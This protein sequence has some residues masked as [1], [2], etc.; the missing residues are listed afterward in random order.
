MGG[1]GACIARNTW[2]WRS[3]RQPPAPG[4][5]KYGLQLAV[6]RTRGRVLIFIGGKGYCTDAPRKYER[7][8]RPLTE[9]VADK[10]RSVATTAVPSEVSERAGKPVP[11]APYQM[12]ARSVGKSVGEP[13]VPGGGLRSKEQGGATHKRLTRMQYRKKAPPSDVASA[14]GTTSRE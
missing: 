8:P 4:R 13:A 10:K 11:Q 5:D 3:R 6:I 12:G 1:L 9:A 7:P 2:Y 14:G